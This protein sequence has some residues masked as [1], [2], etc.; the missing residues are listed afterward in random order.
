MDKCE[1]AKTSANMEHYHDEIWGVPIYEDR[2]LFRKLIL[3]INQAGLSWQTILNKTSAF[4]QAFDQFEIETVANYKEEKIQELLQNKGIIRNRR[5]I[6][7]AIHN[8][9]AV[10]KIQAEFGSFSDYL[11]QFTDHRTIHTHRHKN[12]AMIPTSELSDRIS[13]ELK[14]RGFKFIGSTIIYAFL[15]AV[16]IINDHE[17]ECFRYKELAKK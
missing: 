9:Q 13:K 7:A 2:L 17:I 10:K 16:G 8:A 4:D 12:E 3:D 14:K 5:K 1:W 6:E 15:Q 11:W